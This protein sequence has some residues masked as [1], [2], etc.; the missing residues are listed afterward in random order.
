MATLRGVAWLHV[1]R[2]LVS[3]G[4]RLSRPP[5]GNRDAIAGYGIGFASGAAA[6]RA[7]IFRRRPTHLRPAAVS[8][9]ARTTI[10]LALGFKAMSNADRFL[11]HALEPIPRSSTEHFDAHRRGLDQ[12]DLVDCPWITRLGRTRMALR[13]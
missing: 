1:E 4:R 9:I 11:L 3:A 13:W 5:D 10:G 6:P 8:A 12:L 2:R 7:T